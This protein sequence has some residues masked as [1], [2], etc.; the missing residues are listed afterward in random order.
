MKK[1]GQFWYGDFMI[2]M[3]VMIVLGIIFANSIVEIPQR[4]S[5]LEKISDDGF[6]IA[7]SLLSEGYDMPNWKNSNGRIGFMTNGKVDVDKLNEFASLVG[8]SR[9]YLVSQ[10]L[11]GTSYQYAF[12]FEDSKGNVI[13]QRAYGGVAKKDELDN[14]N[15]ENIFR[16]VRVVYLDN[17]KD[18]K[19]ELV[20]MH[21]VVWDIGK[22]YRTSKIVCQNAQSFNFCGFLNS[23]V[24]DY[25]YG[26]CDEW[27]LCG[28]QPACTWP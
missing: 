5:D 17:N 4:E 18:G 22:E 9:G 15:A 8:T 25:R 16:I 24:P 3:L 23:L 2:A 6:T 7:N 12:Y 19:G 1:R 28:S 20:K 10:F 21:L 11:F 26:C 13:N 14:V 27:S